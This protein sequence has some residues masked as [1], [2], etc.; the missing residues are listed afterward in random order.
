MSSFVIVFLGNIMCPKQHLYSTNELS[1]HK[2]KD[3]FT[4]IRGEVFRL[5]GIID[6]HLS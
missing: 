6:A 2:G 1:G 3:A 4:V 5:N